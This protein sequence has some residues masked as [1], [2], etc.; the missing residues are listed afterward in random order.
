M[1]GIETNVRVTKVAHG[2][3]EVGVGGGGEVDEIRACI[4]VQ[5]HAHCD[6]NN[7]K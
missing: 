6:I 2:K 1:S 5:V 3:R 4:D 7:N